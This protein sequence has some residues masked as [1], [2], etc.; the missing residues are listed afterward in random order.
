VS[1]ERP[2]YPDRHCA[3][4]RASTEISPTHGNITPLGW[5]KA[6]LSGRVG[7]RNVAWRVQGVR[8]QGV[9]VQG[10]RVQGVRVQGRRVQGV[11][12]QGVRV[13]GVKIQGVRVQGVRVQGVRVQGVRVQGVKIQGVRVQGV[14]VQGVRVQGV[15]VQGVRVQGVRLQGVV[16]QVSRQ[17]PG[18]GGRVS[19]T[20]VYTKKNATRVVL[21][22]VLLSGRFGMRN[23]A[24][25]V[26]GFSYWGWNFGRR[27]SDRIGKCNL[28][29]ICGS[30]R[31]SVLRAESAR[32]CANQGL[33]FRG[34][35]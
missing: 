26:Q 13:Q 24:C 32:P 25:R 29:G 4:G 21:G 1:T 23:E 15:R 17:D 12:I 8:V 28:A 7:M 20:G 18:T 19:S 10:I 2:E 3:G 14:R 34:E 6:L 9:R 11:R 27:D 16:P 31:G 5:S 22:S 35:G 30:D 33:G